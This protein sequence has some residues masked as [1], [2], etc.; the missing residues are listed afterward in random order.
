M[1]RL[2]Q[3]IK[4]DVKFIKSHSLQPPWYKA[5]KIFILAGFLAGYYYLF[6][7]VRTAVFFAVFLFLSLLIHFIYRIKTN[8]WKQSWLDFVVAESDDGI[9]AVSIGKIYYSAIVL[10]VFLSIAVSQMVPG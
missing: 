4:E 9:K 6:G 3:E 5:L 10:N 7:F 1:T 2:L 8:K